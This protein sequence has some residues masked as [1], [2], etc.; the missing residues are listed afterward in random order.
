MKTELSN[1]GNYPK[2]NADVIGIRDERDAQEL[3]KNRKN[4]I[5]RGLGRCYGD[6]ALADNVFDMSRYNRYLSFDPS[7]GQLICQGGVT[8]EDI[9]DTFVPRGWFPP[10]TPG[11]KF[12]TVGG[13]VASDVHGKS[14]DTFCDHVDWIKVLRADGSIT[15]CSHTE[16]SE[17]FETTRGGMGLTG[18]VLEVC[19]KLN[20]IETCYLREELVPCKNLETIMDLFEEDTNRFNFSVAWIDCLATGANMGRSI[21]MRGDHATRDEL[22][23]HEHHEDPLRFKGMPKLTVPF[24]FPNFALNTLTV[25]AF[26]MAYYG[27]NG[28]KKVEHI[29]TYDNFFYPL[30]FVNS[31]NRIYGNRGFTQ[32]QFVLPLARSREGLPVLLD[33]IAHSGLGSFLAVLKRFGKQNGFISFPMEGY[34]LALDFPITRKLFPLL[35]E[36]DELVLKYGGRLYMTK[37]AR[38]A[39]QMFD[40]GYENAALFKQ[41][42]REWDPDGVFASLQ[43]KRL[44]ITR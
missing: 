33:K 18:L 14:H 28:R 24:N 11:T 32:Y 23:A 13:A 16:N 25:K 5:G 10:V 38:M 20:R 41:R 3:L 40:R 1:W 43:S 22:E 19:F 30:D 35:D 31:W 8:L 21:M 2:T 9:L 4:C 37:D 36:L 17:F 12:V 34:T 6:S 15:R 29:T 44:E 42:I 27:M 39:P 7:N 26:N